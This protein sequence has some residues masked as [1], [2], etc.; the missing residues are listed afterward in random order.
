MLKTALTRYEKK[1][2]INQEYLV[3]SNLVIKNFLDVA[4]LI[5]KANWFTISVTL[6]STLRDPTQVR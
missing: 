3:Q 6:L 4:K 1:E 5:T 2:K